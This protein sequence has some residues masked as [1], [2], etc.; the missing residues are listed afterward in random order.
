MRKETNSHHDNDLDINWLT[1]TTGR[2]E[3]ERRKGGGVG[4]RILINYL[5]LFTIVS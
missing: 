4:G 5:L 2:K 1:K 3:E